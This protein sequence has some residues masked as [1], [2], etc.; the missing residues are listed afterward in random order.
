MSPAARTVPLGTFWPGAAHP[1]APPCYA[2]RAVPE[3]TCR[4]TH[5]VN[6]GNAVV[7][8]GHSHGS[9]LLAATVP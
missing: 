5:L 3:L 1:F 2:E 7:L 9:V 8:T 4:I 6:S